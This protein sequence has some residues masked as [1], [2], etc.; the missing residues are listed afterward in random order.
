MIHHALRGL[1]V[2][3]TFVVSTSLA[4]AA[5]PPDRLAVIIAAGDD[6]ALSD[7]LTE[8]AIARVAAAGGRQLVGLEELRERL[9]DI[10]IIKTSGMASCLIQVSCLRQLGRI[11]EVHQA[12][13]G[14]VVS[15]Q[16]RL[17]LDVTLVNT[18]TGEVVAR[19]A[20]ESAQDAQALIAVLERSVQ[21]VVDRP[22]PPV[23]PS[24]Q[25]VPAVR[26]TPAPPK[27]QL[28]LQPAPPARSAELAPSPKPNYLGYGAA[29]LGAVAL[30]AAFFTGR[31]AT[32]EPAGATRA[33]AQADYQRRRDYAQV[34]DGLLIAAGTCAGFSATA[35]IWHW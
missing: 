6:H 35:F 33:D 17:E 24:H 14:N 9:D 23:G 30:T 21:Q 34:T 12:I 11:A 18:D 29:A 25:I 13:L 28:A 1:R 26:F 19:A 2:S 10:E 3:A 5:P 4:L 8:V 7:N 22:A 31:V 32:G 15:H 16:A 27:P 20:H